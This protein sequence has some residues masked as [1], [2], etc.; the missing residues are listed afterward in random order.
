MAVAFGVGGDSARVAVKKVFRYVLTLAFALLPTDVARQIHD[1]STPPGR[2]Y[3]A[4]NPAAAA[5]FNQGAW[6][7]EKLGWHYKRN[8]PALL[9]DLLELEDAG[10]VMAQDAVVFLLLAECRRGMSGDVDEEGVAGLMA[11][12]EL[13]GGA[14]PTPRQREWMARLG[15]GAMRACRL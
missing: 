6:E 1:P 10:E 15:L 13:C 9:L 12:V 8:P 11:D 3:P 7:E 4:L 14:L 5:A 2:I